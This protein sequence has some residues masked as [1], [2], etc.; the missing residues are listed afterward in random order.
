MVT[1]LART[2]AVAAPVEA[3]RQIHRRLRIEDAV[4]LLQPAPVAVP[5]GAEVQAVGHLGHELGHL[6]ALVDGGGQR[7][8]ELCRVHEHVHGKVGAVA[9]LDL[10]HDAAEEP[11][12]VL[13][14]LRPVLVVAMV[15]DPRQEGVAL[16]AGAVVELAGVE[17]GLLGPFSRLGPDVHHVLDLLLGHGPAGQEIGAGKLF[18][19]EGGGALDVAHGR[20]EGQQTRGVPRTRVEQLDADG[21]SLGVHCLDEAR[22]SGDVLVVVEMEL[23]SLIGAVR[24]VAHMVDA[25][26]KLDPRRF[27]HQVPRTPFGQALVVGHHARP[28]RLVRL[29]ERGAVGRLED[30]VAGGHRA[31]A[32]GLHEL[33][34]AVGHRT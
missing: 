10:A 5:L 26:R 11:G 29:H 14:A 4:R 19:G 6:G 30:A 34:V 15:P 25:Q 24:E 7:V 12:A 33:F 17:S 32:A 27:H 23:D 31:Y 21:A 3:L 2:A 9:A 16:V 18:L 20:V 8:V 22:I 13:E 28:H 1:P